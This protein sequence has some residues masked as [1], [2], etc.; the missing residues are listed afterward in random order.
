M[1]PD[2]DFGDTRSIEPAERVAPSLTGP[3]GKA[4]ARTI[5]GPLGEHAQVGRQWF[6]TPLRIALLVGVFALMLSWFGKAAC[7]QQYTTQ[8]GKFELDWR[9][10]RPYIT[11]CYTDIVPLYTAEQLDKPGS[12]PYKTTWI[13]DE[14]KP[15]QQT[16]YM[17]YP[18]LTGLF[19]WVNA[20]LTAGWLD[21]GLAQA[22]PVAI[23]FDIS[24]FWLALA[25]LVTVFATVRIARRRPWDAVLVAASPLVLVHAFTNFDALAAAAAAAG[26][27]AWA[28]RKPVPAGVLI[29]IGAAAKFYPLFL[30][31]ALFVL[32]LRAGKLRE[33]QRTTVAALAAWLVVNAPIAYLYPEG[34]WE[35]FRR[36]TARAAD[37]DSIW[38]VIT[39][40]TGWT[41]FDGHLGPWQTPSVLNA[42]T[43]GLFLACCAA[44]AVMALSAPVRPRVAQLGFLLV[45]AFLLI[46]KV[47]S[48]QY[49]LWLVPL[50]VLAMPRWKILLAWMT[51]DALVWVPRMMYYLG[52]DHKGLPVEWFLGWVVVRDLAVVA[53]C[54]L[55][56]YEIY[57]PAR[58]LVR[59]AGDDDPA[60]GVLDG[61][62]DR[63]LLRAGRAAPRRP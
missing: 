29:G 18:V 47:W 39:E 51:I 22:I 45:A 25:W 14:G 38:N 17:E 44:V 4:A 63:F 13:D 53:L 27:L 31:G 28:R 58:D 10:S 9:T 37:T 42:V 48:P 26:M 19:Q 35:F 15:T 21:L 54:A 61:A 40:F 11:M 23:Y 46:N 52:V 34:W 3:L 30:L 32:C 24:A 7:I 6:W 41:G 60:G 20:K 36:N 50:A 16:R 43:A 56:V 49:S 62:E 33:W 55:V 12:F 1:Q 8:D 2:D 5:G 57:H 59:L